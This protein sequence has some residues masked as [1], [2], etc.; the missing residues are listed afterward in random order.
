MP[1]FQKKP[2]VIEAMQYTGDNTSRLLSWARDLGAEIGTGFGGKY[3]IVTMLEGEMRANVGDWIIKGVRGEFYPC[4][5]DIFAATHEEVVAL[6]TGEE[7]SGVRPCSSDGMTELQRMTMAVEVAAQEHD[8]LRQALIDVAIYA[9]DE[10]PL[11]GDEPFDWRRRSM[12]QENIARRALRKD[13][14]STDDE[15]P[16][17]KCAVCNDSGVPV[18][19]FIDGPCQACGKD[20]EK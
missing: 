17:P 9:Q 10:R 20:G 4:K 1:F 3:L 5:P 19:G 7:S 2:V 16:T 15:T 14:V 11:N 13:A 8:R 12:K 6:R 18:P